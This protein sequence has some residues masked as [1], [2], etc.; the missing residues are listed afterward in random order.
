MKFKG[1]PPPGPK[2]ED[3]D[4]YM[5][6]MSGEMLTRFYGEQYAQAQGKMLR[7]F[8]GILAQKVTDVRKEKADAVAR[9]EAALAPYR[10][11]IFCA[12]VS[13]NLVMGIAEKWNKLHPSYRDVTPAFL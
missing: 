10:L 13:M 12:G 4:L 1:A 11:N 9:L 5:L 6:R 2:K 7:N 8:L 3:F